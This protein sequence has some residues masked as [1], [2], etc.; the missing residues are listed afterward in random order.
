MKSLMSS[1]APAMLLF[2]VLALAHGDEDPAMIMDAASSQENHT[3]DLP[4]DIET[5]NSY[6][7]HPEHRGALFAHI[8]TMSVAWVV[9]MPVGKLM[10]PCLKL[11][12]PCS[13]AKLFSFL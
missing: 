6:F 12:L 11:D 10:F 8:I 7:N 4:G 3:I 2:A 9:A 1:L 13:P 5:P